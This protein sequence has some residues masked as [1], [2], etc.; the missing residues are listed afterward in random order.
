VDDRGFIHYAY[1]APE[2]KAQRL[3]TTMQ[4]IVIGLKLGWITALLVG[5][6]LADPDSIVKPYEMEK[7]QVS[8]GKIDELVFSALRKEGIEPARPCSDAVFV[9]RVYLD[10]IGIPPDATEVRAFLKDSRSDKRS[11][12]IDSLLNRKEY[13]DYWSM[14]W[15]D[16]LRVKSEFPINLWPNAVHAYQRWIHEA[17]R[18]NLP[19]DRM[20][21]ELLTASGSN[22]RV[23]Q[24]NFHRAV[25][26]SGPQPLAAAVAL[27]FMGSRI[28]SWPPDRRA[29]L[30]ALFSRL[31][32]K[33]TAEWKEEIVCLDPA[34][35]GP[36]T[37]VLPDGR[38]VRVPPGTDPRAVF[39]DWLID[40]KNRWFARAGANRMWAWV[41][42]RGIVHEP[43]DLRPDNPPSIPGLLEHLE[44]EFAANQ[45]DMRKLLRLILNSQVYQLSPIPR[46]EDPRAAAMFACYPVRRLEAEVLLDALCL[47]TGTVEGYNSPIPEPFTYIPASARSV[48]LAD[49][50]ITS[51]FLEMF[52]RS[53]R[54]SG[55]F[56]ERNNRISDSQ[57]LHLLN[58]SQVQTKIERSWR[59]RKLADTHRKD[60]AALVRALWI[61]VLSRPP[62]PAEEEAALAHGTE[63]KLA[64]K[65]A[66]DDLVWALINSKEFL[67]RH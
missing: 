60:P 49:G 23:P 9:R 40:P 36:L 4:G 34:P 65:Q 7:F 52:G 67:Y 55:Y 46:S 32:F 28:E 61:A 5:T 26:G 39:A 59:L 57:R 30:E 19:Y 38:K 11:V 14:K 27:T 25:Q 48:D 18:D 58:S 35:L 41:F 15:C 37:A 43:D 66:T 53:Q 42:G 64:L 62:L 45:Y 21:R 56:T 29:G 33:P 47:L 22:F 54:D 2:I 20:A 13:V 31:A 44:R 12:L 8:R 3:V 17:L 50:S 24:V 51:S 6:A 1:F 63:S 16:L 10:V